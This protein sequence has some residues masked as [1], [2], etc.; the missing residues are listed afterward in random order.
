MWLRIVKRLVGKLQQIFVIVW[1]VSKPDHNHGQI[2]NEKQ[3]EN[4]LAGKCLTLITN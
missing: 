3:K 1:Q 2:L 4:D